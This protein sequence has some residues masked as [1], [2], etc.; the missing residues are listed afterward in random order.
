MPRMRTYLSAILA[1]RGKSSQI[2]M[3]GTLVGMGRNSPRTSDGASGLRSHM[4]WWLGPPDRWTLMIALEVVLPSRASARRRSGRAK[5]PR[6]IAPILRKLRRAM[7]SQLGNRSP[8]MV[9]MVR[10]P[11][12]PLLS[13]FPLVVEEEFLRIDQGPDDVLEGRR[14]VLR[15]ELRDVRRRVL[16]LVLRGR[17]AEGPEVQLLDLVDVRTLHIAGELFRYTGA[18]FSVDIRRIEQVQALGERRVDAALAL[19]G[20][21]AAGLAEHR[22]EV[23]LHAAVVGDLDRARARSPT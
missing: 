1:R 13:R 2:S 19:A 22:E 16:H 17:A 11:F 4:S 9:N 5:P 18:H 15:F 23:G 3:P 14:A 12:T 10:P 8:V 7:P 6:P 20:A 21:G